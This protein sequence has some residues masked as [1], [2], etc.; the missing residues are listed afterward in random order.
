[1]ER[2]VVRNFNEDNAWTKFVE[3]ISLISI[4]S[5]I[6]LTA[7]YNSQHTVYCQPKRSPS[8]FGISQMLAL[9]DFHMWVTLP[10]PLHANYS[11]HR[12]KGQTGGDTSAA[13]PWLCHFSFSRPPSFRLSSPPG[14]LEFSIITCSST[15]ESIM[16]HLSLVHLWTIST[17][18]FY[19]LT[20]ALC[21][22]IPASSDSFYCNA[23]SFLS[24][25]SPG[26]HL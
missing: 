1:M 3:E 4:H 23:L 14:R 9:V 12:G 26:F 5:W 8:T 6:L 13:Q 11:R 17:R 15:M 22:K 21:Q 18:S 10:W 25:N 7:V 16:L 20:A 24:H 19:F 2:A